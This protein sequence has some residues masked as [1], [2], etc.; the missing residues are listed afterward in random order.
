MT[1]AAIVGC[2]ALANAACG[3]GDKPGA[4]DRQLCLTLLNER[5][6]GDALVSCD[7]AV[8]ANARDRD[9]R[10]ARAAVF[11]GLGNAPLSIPDLTS[12]IEEDPESGLAL[13]WRG[14]IFAEMG[15]AEQ[16]MADLPRALELVSTGRLGGYT[17]SVDE[18]AVLADL[19]TA[20]EEQ[21]ARGAPML[22]SE[23]PAL[24]QE[25]WPIG[26]LY[27]D[28]GELAATISYLAPAGM[29]NVSAS[30]SGVHGPGS[31][32]YDHWCTRE[33]R[34]PTCGVRM[35][36]SFETTPLPLVEPS[37]MLTLVGLTGGFPPASAASPPSLEGFVLCSVEIRMDDGVWGGAFVTQ[38]FGLPCWP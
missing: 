7:A 6:F 13:A 18:A 11:I 2:L 24:L 9:A 12:L 25:P 38:T 8:E 10:A 26:R 16:A 1:L 29:K 23:A 27:Q 30:F 17:I 36:S 21:G 15:A 31:P 5:R 33:E 28:G 32:W 35:Y 20:V 22:S 34:P 14:L 3:A 37:G 19:A 4:T